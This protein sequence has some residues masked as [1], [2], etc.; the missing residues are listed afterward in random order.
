M[1]C[2][3][4]GRGDSVARIRLISARLALNWSRVVLGWS[5]WRQPPGQCPLAFRQP[6]SAPGW[7]FAVVKPSL[8]TCCRRGRCPGL[9]AKVLS[10]CPACLGCWLLLGALSRYLFVSAFVER[11]L[12][13]GCW[14]KRCPERHCCWWLAARG[15]FQHAARSRD[16]G[17]S[18]RRWRCC[19][20]VGSERN[21]GTSDGAVEPLFTCCW[22]TR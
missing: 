19:R 4:G 3:C 12:T 5:R 21:S 9:S 18:R 1:C 7:S 2:C 6:S 10:C 16:A 14:F 17:C 22:S 15:P 13:P 8:R 11:G 20:S